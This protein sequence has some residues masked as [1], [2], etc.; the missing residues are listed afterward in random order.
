MKIS[1]WFLYDE[2]RIFKIVGSLKVT[3]AIFVLSMADKNGIATEITAS[4]L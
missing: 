1:S 3:P 2:K 4:L